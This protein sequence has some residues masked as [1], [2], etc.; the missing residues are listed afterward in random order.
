MADEVLFAAFI[1]AHPQ[2]ARDDGNLD[3]EGYSAWTDWLRKVSALGPTLKAP[4][5]A[6]QAE[7]ERRDDAFKPRQAGESL[8]QFRLRTGLRR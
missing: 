5:A 7:L 4:L 6:E 8:L 3:P 2:H 1:R